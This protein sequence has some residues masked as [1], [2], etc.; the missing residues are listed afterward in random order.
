MRRSVLDVHWK[1]WCWSW[2]S[3]TL[4][5]SCKELTHWK[6]PGCW[7]GLGAR[8]EG[9]D[10]G[11]DGWMASPTRWTWVW[12][13]SGSWWWTGRPGV[14]WFMGSQRVGHDWAT[15]LDWT[16]WAFSRL[17]SLHLYV[18]NFPWYKIFFKK[19]IDWKKEAIKGHV[20]TIHSLWIMYSVAPNNNNKLDGNSLVVQWLGLGG[21]TAGAWVW[22]LVGE[23]RSCN[24]YDL[25]KKKKKRRGDK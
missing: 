6:R 11:W 25:A 12:V 3:N 23:L 5:T 2:N 1:D 16:E 19:I 17:F 21:F 24:L 14:L 8:G 9:D 13:N 15:E 7:E 4:A 18:W 20:H 10:S 22:S